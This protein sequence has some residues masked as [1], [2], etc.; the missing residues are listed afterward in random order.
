M[1]EGAAWENP[2]PEPADAPPEAEPAI[3]EEADAAAA[4]D[5]ATEAEPASH[6]EQQSDEAPS[7]P[8]AAAAPPGGTDWMAAI[9]R[10]LG[11]FGTRRAK[12]ASLG[13]L[14][15]LSACATLAMTSKTDGIESDTAAAAGNRGAPAGAATTAVKK[16]EPLSPEE[17]RNAFRKR[18]ADVDRGTCGT[19]IAVTGCS[20]STLPRRG[21]QVKRESSVLAT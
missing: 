20:R 13:A 9:R 4:E 8:I 1:E 14:V 15:V 3:G 17:L 18:L 16:E 11:M 12:F 7:E 5:G 21:Q 6:T 10:R 2:P 19:I